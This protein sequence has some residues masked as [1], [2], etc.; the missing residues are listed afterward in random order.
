MMSPW[1][2]NATAQDHLAAA[3][4]TFKQT[5]YEVWATLTLNQREKRDAT[6]EYDG[7]EDEE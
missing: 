3:G 7:V 6:S 1:N 4:K 5:M 2:S